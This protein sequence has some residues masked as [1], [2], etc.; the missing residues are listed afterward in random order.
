MGLKEQK[1]AVKEEVLTAWFDFDNSKK[2]LDLQKSSTALV[3]QNRDL[4]EAEYKA[5]NTSLVRLT[6]AQSNLI[7]TRSIY[8]KSAANLQLAVEKIKAYTGVRD[9]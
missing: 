1:I 4:I 9:L 2:Q 5:G 8:L 3:K 7:K 6:E